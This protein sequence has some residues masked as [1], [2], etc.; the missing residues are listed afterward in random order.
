MSTTEPVE[1]RAAVLAGVGGWVPPHV[2]TNDDLSAHLDTSDE[3]I[4]T[5]TGIRTRH[6]VSPG[7][8]TS[9]LAVE[10]GRR[11]LDSS[12]DDRAGAVVLATTTPD[13]ICPATAPDVAAR[14]G[15]AGVPAFDVSAVC[16]GFLYGLAT[17]AG[18]IATG[19]A[20]RVLLIGADAFTTIV[21]PTDRSTAVIF[22]DGA[23]PS[24]CGPAGRRSP[25]RSAR[26]CWAPT[27]P[28]AI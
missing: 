26:W 2:V 25:A 24:C 23:G 9:D 3:W 28:S 13:R 18:L 21:D 17:A 14:L 10:A 4:R 11:A 1:D 27:G 6:R 20:E 7:M 16:T 19:V 8:A 5:R 22:A 15:L 12:G